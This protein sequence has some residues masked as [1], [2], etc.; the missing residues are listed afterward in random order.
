[1]VEQFLKSDSNEIEKKFDSFKKSNRYNDVHIDKI[2]I[3]ESFLLDTKIIKNR[4]LSTKS[5][6]EINRNKTHVLWNQRKSVANRYVIKF[7]IRWATSWKKHFIPNQILETNIWKLNQST[8]TVKLT[9]NF[10]AMKYRQNF[11]LFT[12][13]LEQCK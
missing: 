9:H 13:I 5:S 7:G 8:M 2:I 1:M 11:L 10:S 4:P 12:N 3:S 6:N